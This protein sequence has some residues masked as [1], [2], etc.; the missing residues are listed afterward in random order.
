MASCS[1]ALLSF[2]LIAVGSFL[3]LLRAAWVIL[4]HPSQ[5]L[6]KTPRDGKEIALAIQM[7]FMVHFTV[8]SIGGHY[9]TMLPADWSISTSH[10]PMPSNCHSEKIL[11]NPSIAFT[12]H[13]HRAQT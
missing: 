12:V 4:R 5:A 9:I 1:F 6:K 3:A 10:D 11:C 2:V 13:Q 8:G 7:D